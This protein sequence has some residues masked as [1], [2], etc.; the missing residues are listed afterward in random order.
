MRGL[1]LLRLSRALTFEL[2]EERCPE[3]TL[4]HVPGTH[5]T[6]LVRP[7]TV[8]SCAVSCYGCTEHGTE[9]SVVRRLL[10]C[11]LRCLRRCFG[12]ASRHHC[13]SMYIGIG[14]RRVF[15]CGCRPTRTGCLRVVVLAAS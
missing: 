1:A 12:G 13:T 14:R 8:P 3:R 11:L 6:G 4:P 5:D 9:S 15:R 10:R 2:A 7:Y